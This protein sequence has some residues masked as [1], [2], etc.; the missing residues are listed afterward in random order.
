MPGRQGSGTVPDERIQ[1]VIE[2]DDLFIEIDQGRGSPSRNIMKFA[3]AALIAEFFRLLETKLLLTASG[4][5]TLAM[6]GLADKADAVLSDKW[7]SRT[8]SISALSEAMI[9]E[10]LAA[11]DQDD[12][13]ALQTCIE[14]FDIAREMAAQTLLHL[15]GL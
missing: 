7:P 11:P 2:G 15:R 3:S 10:V 1:I 6:D 12:I 8:Q 9:R 14:R 5:V 4:E 13:A